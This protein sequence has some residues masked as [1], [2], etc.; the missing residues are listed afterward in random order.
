MAEPEHFVVDRSDVAGVVE[1]MERLAAAGAGWINLRPAVDADEAPQPAAGIFAVFGG[2]GPDVPLCTW[3]AG[4]R[5]KG[6]QGDPS[7]GI[8]HSSGT[9]AAARLAEAGIAVPQGW[10]VVQDHPKRGLAVEVPATAPHGEVV[11][12]LMRAGEGLSRIPLPTR[13]QVAVHVP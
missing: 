13:W 7:I 6:R 11:T 2:R 3:V 4:E 1:R 8:Q 9:K 5:R 12:W 10:R